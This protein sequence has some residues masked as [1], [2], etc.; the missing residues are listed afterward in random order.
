MR[1]LIARLLILAAPSVPRDLRV[2]V[3]V[4]TSVSGPRGEALPVTVPG[5]NPADEPV[6]GSR[7]LGHP[8]FLLN[9][10]P[11]AELR[12]QLNDFVL[13][14]VLDAWSQEGRTA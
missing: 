2:R 10:R 7:P 14:G 3:A 8:E 5:G 12:G 13:A 11:P 1:R 6:G 9:Y 4:H